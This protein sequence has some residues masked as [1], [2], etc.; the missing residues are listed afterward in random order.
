M[1]NLQIFSLENDLN[2][3]NISGDSLSL[4]SPEIENLRLTAVNE[5]R[6]LDENIK[7]FEKIDSNSDEL[8]LFIKN[9][10]NF[11]NL[12]L[13]KEFNRINNLIAY[14]STI[15][16]NNDIYI[17]EL[18]RKKIM[19][20]NQLNEEVNLFLKSQ[21]KL[22]EAKIKASTRPES[23]LLNYFELLSKAKQDQTILNNFQTSIIKL[24]LENG[25]VQDPWKLITNPTVIPSPVYPRKKRNIYTGIFLGAFLSALLLVIFDKLK[26]VIYS[27][28][29][30]EIYGEIPIVGELN[31]KDKGTLNGEYLEL[32]FNK[33]FEKNP[34]N[35]AFLLVGDVNYEEI[36]NLKSLLDKYIKNGNLCILESVQ[37]SY[38]FE[39]VFLIPFLGTT[40]IYELLNIQELLTLQKKT[41]SGIIIINHLFSLQ[42]LL[43]KVGKR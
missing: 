13:L 3:G 12:E 17:K 41:P 16:K 18:K 38:K 21:R 5:K 28:N 37:E 34:A 31:L 6:I 32:F 24:K 39:K 42:S 1:E 10:P 8:I 23:V 30:I 25:K 20:L 43:N 2:I 11:S 22:I 9:L 15:Y 27:R 14:E 29:E 35:N 26:K 36:N 19:L 7:I 33:F 40:N 4:N